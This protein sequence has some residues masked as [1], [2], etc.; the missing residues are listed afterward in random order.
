MPRLPIDCVARVSSFVVLEWPAVMH[1]SRGW[2]AAVRWCRRT[3]VASAGALSLGTQALA[4]IVRTDNTGTRVFGLLR[5]PACQPPPTWLPPVQCV[6]GCRC[7]TG[8]VPCNQPWALAMP[9]VRGASLLLS[10]HFR[11]RTASRT[12]SVLRVAGT[13]CNSAEQVQGPAALCGSCWAGVRT[14][15]W[16]TF[17]CTG[18]NSL[19]PC[20]RW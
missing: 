17:V 5:E 7:L 2:C 16:Q 14:P 3:H 18:C 8:W 1:V 20:S 12:A 15:P 6:S 11:S 4:G 9:L 19:T 13:D 10:A